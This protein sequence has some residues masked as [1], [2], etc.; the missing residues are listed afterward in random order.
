MS[1]SG[2]C[3]VAV[4]KQWLVVV[5]LRVNGLGR[6]LGV[7]PESV[8]FGLGGGFYCGALEVLGVGGG[9]GVVPVEGWCAIGIIL[10][11]TVV[12]LRYHYNIT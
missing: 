2:G 11:M 5:I 7:L 9:G 1:E 12:V 3:C 8:D 10:F 4:L 6:G